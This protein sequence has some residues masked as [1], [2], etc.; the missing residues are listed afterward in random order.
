MCVCTMYVCTCVCACACVHVCVCVCVC[1]CVRACVCVTLP[2]PLMC[3]HAIA[4]R[5]YHCADIT[6]PMVYAFLASTAGIV[7]GGDDSPEI[8]HR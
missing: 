5:S 6:Y 2:S 1:V 8:D 3:A 7:M 4:P